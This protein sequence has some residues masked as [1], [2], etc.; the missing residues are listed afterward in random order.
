MPVVFCSAEEF[1][2]KEV[3]SELELGPTNSLSCSR[4]DQKDWET[5]GQE[6]CDIHRQV[7][8]GRE[9]D[10]EYLSEVINTSG[11]VCFILSPAEES[12]AVGYTIACPT[13]DSDSAY[14]AYTAIRP[15]FQ[16][17]GHVATLMDALEAELKSQ[18]YKFIERHC[19]CDNG[20][21][22]IVERHY[23]DRIVDQEESYD[24]VIGYQ[25]YFRI[26]L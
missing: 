17:R 23:G 25:R 24:D 1:L 7:F 11:G 13:R 3:L 16:G 26:R 4:Y 9:W 14:I 10:S 15:E 6:L 22:L 12:G 8:W 2:R 19:V 20:Y 21:D 18:G 5:T